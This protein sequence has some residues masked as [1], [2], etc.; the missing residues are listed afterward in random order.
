VPLILWV[1]DGDPIEGIDE[2]SSHVVG[3]LGV[4]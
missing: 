2:D 3:R 4:P 1:V